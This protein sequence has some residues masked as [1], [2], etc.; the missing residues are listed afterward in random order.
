MLQNPYSQ[1]AA[2]ISLLHGYNLIV[3]LHV[4]GSSAILMWYNAFI[5]EITAINPFI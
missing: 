4:W 1:M 3:C 5:L 2:K